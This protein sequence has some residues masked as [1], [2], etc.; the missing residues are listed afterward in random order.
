MHSVW[1]EVSVLGLY[2]LSKPATSHKTLPKELKRV[3]I[4]H[5]AHFP[6][7]QVDTTQS[8]LV[9]TLD[10]SLDLQQIKS[11]FPLNA[12]ANMF[13]CSKGAQIKIRFRHSEK[14]INVKSAHLGASLPQEISNTFKSSEETQAQPLNAFIIQI[15]KWIV[16]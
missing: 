8:V 12:K 7:S 15:N 13:N 14:N 9:F 10:F 3:E 6:F 1:L 5:Q 11:G 4:I 2:P 16:L